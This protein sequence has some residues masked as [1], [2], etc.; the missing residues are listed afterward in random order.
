MEFI[1]YEI[2][3][4]EYI[5]KGRK[6][7]YIIAFFLGSI[8]SVTLIPLICV[9][10][11]SNVIGLMLAIITAFTSFYLVSKLYYIKTIQY[12]KIG[13]FVITKQSIELNLVEE[14]IYQ[15]SELKRIYYKYDKAEFAFLNKYPRAFSYEIIIIDN[16]DFKHTLRILRKYKKNSLLPNIKN[17]FE[18]IVEELRKINYKIYQTI[19]CVE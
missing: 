10:I 1:E 8:L 7:I 2:V 9:Q 19:R 5:S 11:T 3:E 15:F 14:K 4:F 6:F 13:T 18:T 17:D 12:S 16:Y